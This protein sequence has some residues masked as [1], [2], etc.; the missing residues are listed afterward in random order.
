M[1][2]ILLVEDNPDA[3]KRIIRYIN[4][5]FAEL[6][7]VSFPEAGDALQYA[8]ANDVSLFILDIQLGS[9]CFICYFQ[10]IIGCCFCNR[11]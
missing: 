5:I 9:G 8:K 3:V 11:N 6:D 7:V 2:K 10:L 1:S 4:K